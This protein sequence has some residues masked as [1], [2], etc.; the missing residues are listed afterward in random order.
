ME[1]GHPRR[2][3]DALA[4]EHA[5]PI[6][7][8]LRGREWT[9]ASQVAEGL[10]I[11]TTTA[12]KYLA[13]F[14]EAGFVDRRSHRARRATHAYRL[15]SPVIRIEFDLAE[16]KEGT[17]VATLAE[18][19][20]DALL[21]AAGRVGGMRLRGELVRGALGGENW[22]QTLRSDLQSSSDAS[23]QFHRLIATVRKTCEDF[24]GG[25][26]AAR[27]LHLATEAATEGRADVARALGLGAGT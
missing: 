23:A 15:R 3:L 13:A 2:A 9:L 1:S 22:R 24:V 12:G 27:L 14:H 20:V 5:L 10:G 18:G 26:A 17:D 4:G 8:F 7:R 11:H 25:A 6:L 21:Q 16:P 19:F